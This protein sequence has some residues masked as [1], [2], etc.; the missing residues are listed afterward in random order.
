MLQIKSENP[1]IQATDRVRKNRV[2]LL[3]LSLIS[4]AP[5]LPVLSL[6]PPLSLSGG[7]AA[8]NRG[9]SSPAVV[10]AAVEGLGGSFRLA[11]SPRTASICCS[12]LRRQ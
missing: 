3:S 11:S 8:A 2:L 5:P 12:W 4:D 1:S 9:L 6:A 10:A 7:A